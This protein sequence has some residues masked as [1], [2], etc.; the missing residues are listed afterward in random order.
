M[1]SFII[2]KDRYDSP[3]FKVCSSDGD[4]IYSVSM[5]FFL[6]DVDQ[7]MSISPQ[8]PSVLDLNMQILLESAIV[9]KI[10]HLPIHGL[11]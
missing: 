3:N 1:R 4:N 7:I 10:I 11:E 9:A 8:T 5:V 6:F 2:S